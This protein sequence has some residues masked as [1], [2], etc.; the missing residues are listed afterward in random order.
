MGARR[1]FGTW[2]MELMPLR[3]FRGLKEVEQLAGNQAEQA[4]IQGNASRVA[5]M[6][7]VP[8]E[9]L[10]PIC[11]QTIDVPAE[12]V[13]VMFAPHF[14]CRKL[15]KAHG[16][17]VDQSGGKGKGKGKGVGSPQIRLIGEEADC[18]A[19]N[20]AIKA[21]DVSYMQKVDIGGRRVG[22]IIGSG[23]EGLRKLE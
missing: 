3:S 17:V 5:Q 15:E 7:G 2:A 13:A 9:K 18:T 20:Q 19:C 4:R 22:G 21:L 8:V 1:C 12:M 6:K 23:G 10:K 16:V 14:L 11:A